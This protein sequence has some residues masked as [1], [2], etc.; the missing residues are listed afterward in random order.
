MGRSLTTTSGFSTWKSYSRSEY[1]KSTPLLTPCIGYGHGL[2]P[3]NG[4]PLASRSG[5]CDAGACRGFDRQQHGVG[6]AEPIVTARRRHDEQ[7]QCWNEKCGPSSVPVSY[8]L[9]DRR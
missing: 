8:Q 5:A 7:R 1:T 4:Q 6:R 9:T 2:F 3:G